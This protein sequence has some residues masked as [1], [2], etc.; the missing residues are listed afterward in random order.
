MQLSEEV[1]FQSQ[2]PS[3]KSIHSVP[4]PYSPRFLFVGA[5][6]GCCFPKSSVL[7]FGE[8]IFEY[9]RAN[10]KKIDNDFLVSPLKFVAVDLMYFIANCALVYTGLIHLSE[11]F[12]KT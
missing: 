4:Q 9:E 10:V 7:K 6:K 1:T 2:P 11:T 12:D 8:D 5:F 3:S